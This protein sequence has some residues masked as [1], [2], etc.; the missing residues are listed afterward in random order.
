MSSIIVYLALCE[1]LFLPFFELLSIAVDKLV[2]DVPR[3]FPCIVACIVLIS[4]HDIFPLA[5]I[6]HV[7]GY[8]I[9]IIFLGF[10][11]VIFS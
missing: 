1:V 9:G 7:F 6:A 2:G 4:T 3:H 11:P 5:V 8:I 10:I